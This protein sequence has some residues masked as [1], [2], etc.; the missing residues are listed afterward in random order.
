MFQHPPHNHPLSPLSVAI[1]SQFIS[2]RAPWNSPAASCAV[3][4][5]QLCRIFQQ[6][7]LCFFASDRQISIRSCL[8]LVVLFSAQTA[9]FH[10]PYQQ[11]GHKLPLKLPC[12]PTLQPRRPRYFLSWCSLLFPHSAASLSPQQ[13]RAG[14]Q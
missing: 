1:G 14:V 5:Q 10:A 12:S 9:R 8:V 2:L 7:P 6:K 3:S 11:L 13:R 4:S